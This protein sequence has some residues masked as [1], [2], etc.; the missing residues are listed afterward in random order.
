MTLKFVLAIGLAAVSN[1]VRADW[2]KVDW[3]V[4][5]TFY[6]EA[7]LVRSSGAMVRMW[8]LSDFKSA[9][10]GGG[11]PFLSMRSQA[12]YDCNEKRWRRLSM[13]EYSGNMAAGETVRT[14]NNPI[15]WR[16]VGTGTALEAL[17]KLACGL[18]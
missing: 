1:G 6:A 9:Q 12:E 17:W 10:M 16:A 18:M 2:V 13:T 14:D 5:R 3:N 8:D 7:A 11:K 4:E 15:G